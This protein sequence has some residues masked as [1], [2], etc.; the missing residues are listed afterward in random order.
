[1]RN[2]KARRMTDWTAG[3]VADIGYTYGYY[4][5]LN[6]LRT[7][8]ALTHAGFKPPRVR[9][10]CELGFGQGV[11]INIHAAASDVH[12][13]GCD[14]NPSQAAFARDLAEMGDTGAMLTDEAFDAFCRREDLPDFDFI[15]L[16][17]IWSWV[18]DDNRHVIVDF[19]RRKLRPG[20]VVYLSY[21]THPG[22]APYLPLR[23][24]LADYADT[25]GRPGEGIGTRI[26]QALG[27]AE[28]LLATDPLYARAN[29]RVAQRLQSMQGQE[30]AYLAHE[31]FN[32]DWRPMPF[33]EM[34]QWLRQ[35]KLSYACSA[36]FLDHV[37]VL[38]L[39]Q[40][41]RSLLSEVPDPT[42]RQSVRDLMGN[43]QFR[44]DYWVKG[45][46]VLEPMERTER[47]REQQ[48]VLTTPSSDLTLVAKGGLGEATLNEPIYRPIIDQL[49][50]HRPKSL[51]EI[52]TRAAARGIQFPQVL[53]AVMI[54]VGKG[55]LAVVGDALDSSQ[56]N[57]LKGRVSRLN[58]LLARKS[59]SMPSLAHLAS[60]VT[61]GGI[62][63]SRFQQLFLLAMTQGASTP[64]A[65]AHEVWQWLSSQGHRLTRDKETLMRPED[66]LEELTRR[67]HIFAER[68]GPVFQEI[69][70]ELAPQS[71][72]DPS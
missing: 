14:F 54:L 48:V 67:A 32:R 59:R 64:D 57:L 21:N 55:D 15:G 27:F 2:Y 20:G 29:P 41:Q 5:E 49:S 71:L 37:E 52:G 40:D 36:H 31:F 56:Q 4:H 6:P 39:T 69:G 10:A 8:L 3:Y 25:M 16:H 34:A 63:V 45:A 58:T 12:W 33:A 66:N 35:A 7:S 65:M 1:M 53:E 22:W 24:L 13:Y 26:D 38:N 30:R 50:D 46:P 42:L 44:R 70:I 17:G 51:A 28:R 18:S 61:G 19:L 47:L 11:S 60:S 9:T 43:V 62:A 68:Q 72:P 23:Q